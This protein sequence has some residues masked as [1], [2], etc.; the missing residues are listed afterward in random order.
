MRVVVLH[1][2]DFAT[3]IWYHTATWVLKSLCIAPKS[4]VAYTGDASTHMI[5]EVEGE[6]EGGRSTVTA[7]TRCRDRDGE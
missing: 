6:G 2:D 3:A 7:F 4:R 5:F 1:I